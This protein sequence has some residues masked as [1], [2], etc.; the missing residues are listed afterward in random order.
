MK[1]ALL[2]ERIRPH[3]KPAGVLTMALP[4]Y[5]SFSGQLFHR[6][7]SGTLHKPCADTSHHISVKFWCGNGGFI[8]S[9]RERGRTGGG[10]LFGET[11]ENAIHCAVCEGKA[12]GAGCDGTRVINGRHVLFS[13][14]L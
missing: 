11:P 10:E 3:C 5:R 7:R 1:V 4:F 9:R 14:R 12:V 6:V 8:D 2:R 13:P